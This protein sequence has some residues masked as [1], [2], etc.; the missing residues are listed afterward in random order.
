MSLVPEDPATTVFNLIDTY[1][2][3][4]LADLQKPIMQRGEYDGLQNQKNKICVMDESGRAEIRNLGQNSYRRV[5]GRVPIEIWSTVRANVN[6]MQFEVDRIMEAYSL[7]PGGDL[8]HIWG[9]VN[10]QPINQLQREPDLFNKA[11]T[12][13]VVYD[14]VVTRV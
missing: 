11:L 13:I 4:D 9:L 5:R 12:C 10:W 2:D 3:A 7:T 6:N 14:R 1:W 8:D